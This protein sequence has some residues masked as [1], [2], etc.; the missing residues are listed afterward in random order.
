MTESSK[1]PL[2]DALDA[3]T[4]EDS[5]GYR[6]MREHA[7]AIEERLHHNTKSALEYAEASNRFDHER[8]D[9]SSNEARLIPAG[10]TIDPENIT[11]KDCAD[12]AACI[13]REVMKKVIGDVDALTETTGFHPFFKAGLGL[14]CEEILFRLEVRWGERQEET[15]SRDPL[16]VMARVMEGPKDVALMER[17]MEKPK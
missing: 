7:R 12:L 15:R 14:A 11:D 16:A 17:S 5:Q 13:E 2:T 1:T 10:A 9:V 6:T 3:I 4:D 8:Q